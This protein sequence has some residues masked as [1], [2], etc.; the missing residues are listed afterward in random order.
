M[1]TQKPFLDIFKSEV[2]DWW[3]KNSVEEKYSKY[4]L[5]CFYI[6]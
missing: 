2:G 1:I 4:F 6:T 5:H 3:F